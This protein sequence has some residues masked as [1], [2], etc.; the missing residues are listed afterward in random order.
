M[1]HLIYISSLHIIIYVNIYII[2][3]VNTS[4]VN[5]RAK[6]WGKTM[7]ECAVVSLLKSLYGLSAVTNA[8]E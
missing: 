1:Y 4:I 7:W 2:I 6:A 5:L 3:Y 8:P